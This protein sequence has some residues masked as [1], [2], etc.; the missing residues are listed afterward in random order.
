MSKGNEPPVKSSKNK[1][2]TTLKKAP[3]FMCTVC[4]SPGEPPIHLIRHNFAIGVGVK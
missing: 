1:H 4:Q 2:F 3:Y